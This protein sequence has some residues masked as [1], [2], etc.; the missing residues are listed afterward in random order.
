M[1]I[2]A[3]NIH[4]WFEGI[5][6]IWRDK[7]CSYLQ[8]SLISRSES[9]LLLRALSEPNLGFAPPPPL[10]KVSENLKVDK[11]KLETIMYV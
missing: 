2:G 4:Q 11:K 1:E 6:F 9:D 3:E 7:K 10:S 8:I 5:L